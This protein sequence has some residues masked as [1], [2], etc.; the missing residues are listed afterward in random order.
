MARMG[1]WEWKY[2]V[3]RTSFE[4]RDWGRDLDAAGQQVRQAGEEGEQGQSQG[5]RAGKD[6]GF[7]FQSHCG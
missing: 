2:A 7:A 4:A 5:G 3:R 1:R 6:A